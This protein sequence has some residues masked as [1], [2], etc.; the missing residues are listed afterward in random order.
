[1]S[2]SSATT[3][4]SSARRIGLQH[5]ADGAHQMR[6]DRAITADGIGGS[7]GVRVAGDGAVARRPLRRRLLLG[8]LVGDGEKLRAA[9][10]PSDGRQIAEHVAIAMSL[11]SRPVNVVRL[12]QAR[13]SGIEFK[14]GRTCLQSLGQRDGFRL[15]ERTCGDESD[16]HPHVSVAQLAAPSLVPIELEAVL[17]AEEPNEVGV[18][19]RRSE[20]RNDILDRAFR[21]GL[22]LSGDAVEVEEEQLGRL[23]G[24]AVVAAVDAAVDNVRDL[25]PRP[26]AFQ[27]GR[28]A[29]DQEDIALAGVVAKVSEQSWGSLPECSPRAGE[30]MRRWNTARCGRRA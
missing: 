27:V 5:V 8:D 28:R 20:P 23:I 25:P 12:Y 7:F 10:H 9:L 16:T 30:T 15:I 11:P 2:R 1:M 26:P 3:L 13:D 22:P 19:I 18:A 21:V 29:T 24:E 14:L 6:T 17:G 4:A